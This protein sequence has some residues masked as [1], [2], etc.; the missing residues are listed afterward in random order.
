LMRL[1]LDDCPVRVAELRAAV[2]SGDPD[3]VQRAAHAI[4][5]SVATFGA[6][7][8]RDLAADL[9]RAGRE[10]RLGDAAGLLGTLELE[11]ERVN[12]ALRQ[13]SVAAATS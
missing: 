2:A 12:E 11:L 13:E 1:F 6:R 8:A 7:Q 9:E 3:Q 5:G 4:K 10:R